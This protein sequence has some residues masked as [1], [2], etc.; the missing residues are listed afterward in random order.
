MT[1]L[2]IIFCLLFVGF[3]EWQNRKERKS[4]IEAIMSKSLADYKWSEAIGKEEK[5]KPEIP[6]D[7]IPIA[8][9]TDEQ[10]ANAMKKEL[11]A[12]SPLDKLKSLVKR[13]HGI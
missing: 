2:I 3:Q 1:E 5:K 13:K 8:E 10:F 11:G 6:P 4:L 7:L 12:K 9:S